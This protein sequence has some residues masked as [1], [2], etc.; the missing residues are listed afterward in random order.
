MMD[1]YTENETMRAEVRA[2]LDHQFEDAI[3]VC[4]ED[5]LWELWNNAIKTID[6]LDRE[7]EQLKD[8]LRYAK[9]YK[10]P[11]AM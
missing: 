9:V 4:D 10:A 3:S 2:E 6:N 7:V 8:K 11:A 5:V 1:N